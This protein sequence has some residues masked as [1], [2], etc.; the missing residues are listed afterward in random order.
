MENNETFV[1]EQ[2]TENV[3][4]TTEQ[5]PKLYTEEE[6]N[7]KVNEVA[8]KRAAR[9]EARIRK[10][11]ERKYGNLEEVLKTGTGKESVDDIADTF[12]EFYKGKG[13]QFAQKPAYSDDDIEVLARNEADGIIKAGFED[14]VEEVDRLAEIGFENMTTREKALFK[15]LADYRQSEERSKELTQIGVTKDVYESQEFKDF[16]KKFA[17]TT[18]IRDIYDLYQKTQ[19]RKEFKP[20]GSMKNNSA[21]DNGVKDFYSFEEASKFTKKDFDR[22]PALFAAVQKS[23]TKW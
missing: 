4:Q 19:P 20:M 9:K 16:Q 7:A 10:E 17:S 6:F 1:T 21:A 8:G 2:V 11:Y 22:N 14:V 15:T 3:E 13:V 23:M 18:P 12:R 5:S